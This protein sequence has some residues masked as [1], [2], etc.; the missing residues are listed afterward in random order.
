[1]TKPATRDV[2][3]PLTTSLTFAGASLPAQALSVAIAIHM[4][5]YFAASIGVPLAAVAA[6]FGT[7]RLIDVPLE[8]VL[9]LGMDRTRT[10]FGRYRVWMLASVPFL[11][12]GLYYLLNAGPG[13]GAGYL[14]AWLLVM[15]LGSSI[16]G[17]SHLAWASRL[18]RSYDER[19]RL[20]GVLAAVGVVGS[21]SVV[22]IPAVMAKLGYSDAEGMHAMFWYIILLAPVA[23]ALVTLRTPEPMVE[24]AHGPQFRLRD[25]LELVIHHN[26]S[27]V[28]LVDLFMALGV[29]WFAAL[30]IF[31]MRDYMLFDTAATS[32]LL[33]ANIGVGFVG[34]PGIAWLAT[35]IG[36]HRAVM[37]AGA[38]LSLSV[39]I[40]PFLS[41]GDVA[42]F[43]PATLLAGFMSSGCT[44][45]TRAMTADVAEEIRLQQG[46]EQS[47]LLYAMVTLTSK[48][49]AGLAVFLA[50]GLLSWVGYDPQLGKHNAPG[51]IQSLVL[52]YAIGPVTLNLLGLACLHGYSL[53][54]ARAA[55]IR[56]RLEAR[57]AALQP[58]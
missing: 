15:Y 22:A 12:L 54:R 3:L 31:F 9:G 57:D 16:L 2:R 34:A 50:F 1:M 17:L 7:V 45:M 55:D 53:T 58:S 24:E 4:P 51:A 47:A 32:V 49:A 41:K 36:K 21:L 27:R 20:F 19:A 18:A 42:I 46:K 39:I 43:L 35:R 40:M 25:Y 44:V 5:A 28:L 23:I 48:V 10:R 13:V 37:V 30:Y 26:M 8:M 33:M 29:G 52:V 56:A 6:A 11:M 14:I 38:G